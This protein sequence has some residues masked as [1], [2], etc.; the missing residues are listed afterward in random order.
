MCHVHIDLRYCCASPSMSI[1]A[2]L[3][4]VANVESPT[5]TSHYILLSQPLCRPSKSSVPHI[6]Y[7]PLH[8]YCSSDWEASPPQPCIVNVRSNVLGS[9]DLIQLKDVVSP[10]G[11]AFFRCLK[12]FTRLSFSSLLWENNHTWERI[13]WLFCKFKF[14]G[15]IILDLNAI[16]SS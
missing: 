11:I 10:S 1:S 13:L 9:K 12:S 3:L 8:L 16:R 4:S 7:W 2:Y 5:V 6:S 15:Y 14:E